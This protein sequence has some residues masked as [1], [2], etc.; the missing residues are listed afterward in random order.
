MVEEL[1]QQ[2]KNANKIIML[3]FEGHNPYTHEHTRYDQM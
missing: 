3:M 1:S 2:A